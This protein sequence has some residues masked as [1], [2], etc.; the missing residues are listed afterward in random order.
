MEID[1]ILLSKGR[2]G[3]DFGRGFYLSADYMQAVRMSENVVR[4][5][6]TGLLLLRSLSLMK[7]LLTGAV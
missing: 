6:K 5:R 7:L 1:E 4:K 2:H 3:K